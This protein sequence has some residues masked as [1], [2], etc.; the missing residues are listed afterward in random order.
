MKR[1]WSILIVAAM[2]DLLVALEISPR[3]VPQGDAPVA[4]EIRAAND[5]E[6][7]MIAD[8]PLYMIS[9]QGTWSDGSNPRVPGNDWRVLWEPVK[10]VERG[11]GVLRCKVRF[12]KEG[13]YNFRFGIQNEKGYFAKGFKDAAVYAL[14]PDLYQLRPWKGDIHMHS[15]RCGH[16]KLEP[17]VIPAYSRRVGFDFMALSEHWQVA[18]SFEA[19]EAAKPWNCG[20]EIYSGEEIHTPSALMHSVALGHSKSACVWRIQNMDAFARLVEEEMKNPVYRKYELDPFEHLQAAM[21]TLIY[22]KTR[23]YGAKF[24]AYCHPSDYNR[25][26]HMESNSDNFRRYL[27]EAGGCDALELPNS[28]TESYNVATRRNDRLMLMNAYVT[29]LAAGGRNPCIVAASDCHDQKAD[30]FGKIFTVIFARG[31]DLDSFVDAV[32]NHR[33]LGLQFPATPRYICFGPSRLQKFQA[34]LE[35]HYWPG[36]DRLC[37]QQGDLLFK[38]LEGDTSVRGAVEKLAAEIAAYREGF[39]TPVK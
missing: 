29:E 28:A 5:A 31:C 27:M 37:R 20:M 6:K 3:I 18:P 25:G 16:A 4:V 34:F 7:K 12:R 32:K 10:E 15:I 1:I 2:A 14:K 24:I 11:D 26:N 22:R 21:T 39:Y 13:E 38:M 19:I 9:D 30:F 35:R 8:M 17:K 23:E 33:S 36:H